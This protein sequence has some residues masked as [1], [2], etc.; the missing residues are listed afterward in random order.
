MI[1][2]SSWSTYAVVAR[3]TVDTR[4]RRMTKV[5][6]AVID[7][8]LA[9]GAVEAADAH[10]R[11]AARLVEAGAAVLAQGRVHLTLVDVQLATLA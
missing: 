11:V 4:G 7:I 5:L 3:D 6:F 10:A 9:V 1:T 8:V 2:N